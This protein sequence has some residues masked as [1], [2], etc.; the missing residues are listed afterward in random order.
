[1]FLEPAWSPALLHWDWS[2]VPALSSLMGQGSAIVFEKT[3]Y[4]GIEACPPSLG[5]APRDNVFFTSHCCPLETWLCLFSLMTRHGA[6]VLKAQ[7]MGEGAGG[8]LEQG[9]PMF[10]PCY[11]TSCLPG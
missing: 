3:L 7:Y 1:M 8:K 2:L 10:I 6:T 5:L 4:P 9:F 11:Y